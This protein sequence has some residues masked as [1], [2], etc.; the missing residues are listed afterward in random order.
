MKNI[1]EQK[2]EIS[3][4][5]S[6]CKKQLQQASSPKDPRSLVN[7]SKKQHGFLKLALGQQDVEE[8]KGLQSLVLGKGRKG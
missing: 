1:K 6:H 8:V 5:S 4:F 2:A 3:R 7:D